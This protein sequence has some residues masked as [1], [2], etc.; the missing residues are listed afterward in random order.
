MPA[1][2]CDWNIVERTSP[3]IAP[4]EVSDHVVRCRPPYGN[5]SLDVLTEARRHG[6]GFKAAAGLVFNRL[7]VSVTP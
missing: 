5:L 6:V 2:M 4:A 3:L 7:R 1:V